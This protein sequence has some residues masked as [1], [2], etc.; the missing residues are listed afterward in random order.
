MFSLQAEP[1]GWHLQEL[2]VLG[3]GDLQGGLP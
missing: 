1:G 2:R 3:T